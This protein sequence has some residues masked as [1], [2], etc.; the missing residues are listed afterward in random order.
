MVDRIFFFKYISYSLKEILFN[1]RNISL[2]KNKYFYKIAPETNFFFDNTKFYYPL[3]LDL[4]TLKKRLEYK[5]NYYKDILKLTGPCSAF[6]D[7]G[8]DIGE[9]S[10]VYNSICKKKSY[11]TAILCFE[12]NKYSYQILYKNIKGKNCSLYN[13]GVFNCNKI[14]NLNYSSFYFSNTLSNLAKGKS[15][16]MSIYNRRNKDASSVQIKLKKLSSFMKKSLLKNAIVKIDVEG[17]EKE[18]L[19]EI[20]EMNVLPIAILLEINM[21]HVFKRFLKL[22]KIFGSFYNHKKYDLFYYGNDKI[23]YSIN[24]NEI[25]KILY[26]YS[27]SI[28]FILIKKTNL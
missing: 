18:I 28:D 24:F 4:T 23:I 7:F 11:K 5:S 22:K 17:C 8:A 20:S 16:L 1:F 21:H 13:F 15:S 2:K 26:K 14:A 3:T 27:Y 9:D 12:P 19:Q 6:I 10:F 25:S